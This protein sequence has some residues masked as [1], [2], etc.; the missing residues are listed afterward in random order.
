MLVVPKPTGKVSLSFESMLSIKAVFPAK[1]A[2]P[3]LDYE[4]KV[5]SLY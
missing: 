5:F 1:S 2:I 4:N 3:S